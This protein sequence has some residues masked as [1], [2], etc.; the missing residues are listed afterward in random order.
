MK[1]IY[2]DQKCYNYL[3][4]IRIN[5][6]IPSRS[7]VVDK[8]LDGGHRLDLTQLREQFLA[9]GSRNRGH[10]GWGG[11]LLEFKFED[12]GFRWNYEVT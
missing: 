2:P 3:V 8:E 6:V 10:Q 7:F 1:L 4:A 9:F 11:R 5:N 12:L